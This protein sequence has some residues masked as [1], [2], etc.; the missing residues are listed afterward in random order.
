MKFLKRFTHALLVSILGLLITFTMVVFAVVVPLIDRDEVSE[1]LDSSGVYAN[2]TDV[3]IAQ[4][5]NGEQDSESLEDQLA[6]GAVPATVVYD[7]A[8]EV[9]SE[10]YWRQN[11]DSA[12]DN[13]YAWLS[14]EEPLAFTIDIASRS[15]ELANK[16]EQRAEVKFSQ[17]PEC[18]FQLLEN[19]RLNEATCL[20][21]NITP[22]EAAREFADNFRGEESPLAE[23]KVDAVT[24]DIDPETEANVQA[25]YTVA[26]ALPA[27]VLGLVFVIALLAVVTARSRINGVRRLGHMFVIGGAMGAIGFFILRK[28]TENIS[29][30]SGVEGAGEAALMNDIIQPVI[31]VA[32]SQISQRGIR[33]G[34]LFMLLGSVLWAAAYFIH[35]RHHNSSKLTSHE[36][37]EPISTS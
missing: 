15:D 14:N 1:L 25:G 3:A 28:V 9:Y 24:F 17:L 32:L 5:N 34:V 21:S 36:P 37:D 18:S 29:L 10:Q 31:K 8:R 20:P 27:A 30:A 13:T 2:I 23:A 33:A 12:I 35:H 19:Y 16:L 7:A 11:V 26:N 22:D 4:A 6:K